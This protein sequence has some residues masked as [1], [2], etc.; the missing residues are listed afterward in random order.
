MHLLYFAIVVECGQLFFLLGAWD[1][2]NTLR[3]RVKTFQLHLYLAV[4]T[5][6]S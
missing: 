1:R 3:T 5:G 4:A 6:P 2:T